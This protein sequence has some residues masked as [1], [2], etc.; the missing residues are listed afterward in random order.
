MDSPVA[1]ARPPAELVVL[2]GRLAGSRRLVQCRRLANLR[3]TNNGMGGW[4]ACI[5]Q[6]VSDA[7]HSATL[8]RASP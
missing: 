3:F 7:D 8:V 1:A 2:T 5:A 6:E 4:L